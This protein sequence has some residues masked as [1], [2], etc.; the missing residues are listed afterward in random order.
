MN[1]GRFSI[2]A[3]ADLLVTF[4]LIVVAGVA[5][6]VRQ[7][8]P[9]TMSRAFLST[10]GVTVMLASPLFVDAFLRGPIRDAA[11]HGLF[12]DPSP[13][14]YFAP[15]FAATLILIAAIVLFPPVGFRTPLS[16]RVAFVGLSL[17]FLAAN[18]ANWCQ[19]GWCV[20]LGF[21]FAYSWW[22]DAVVVMNDENVSAGTS[23]LA[24]AGNAFCATMA[25]TLMSVSYRLHSKRSTFVRSAGASGF[26]D[27]Q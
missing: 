16:W 14:I 2:F 4:L 27:S 20:R 18:V 7:R 3:A 8:T 15:A 12:M 13:M 22:S 25:A 11:R 17:L 5:F 21:P 26:S 9:G 1:I 6:E 19:P 24:L 10:L 23:G